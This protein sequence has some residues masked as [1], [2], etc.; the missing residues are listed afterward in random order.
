MD[1]E[2][3]FREI[4]DFLKIHEY[5]HSTELMERYPHK[6][7]TPYHDWVREL[8]D[9]S[10]EDLLN[11]EKNFDISLI[12][13]ETFKEFITKC[14]TLSEIPYLKVQ[15]DTISGQ[16]T[17]KLNPKK[18]HELKKIKTLVNKKED[19][20]T[21]IDIGSGAGH[22]SSVLVKDRDLHSICIDMDSDFQK[23]GQKKISHW[24]PEIKDKITFIPHKISNDNFCPIE[25]DKEKS[26][27]IG[28][29][30]CGPLSTYLIQQMP[31]H[32][33]N[34]SCC[35][36]KLHDEY[37]LSLIAK[38]KPLRFTNHALTMAAKCLGT[39]MIDDLTTKFLVKSYRYPIHFHLIDHGKDKF[40]NLGNAKAVDYKGSF[41][42]YIQKYCPDLMHEN[43]SLK[44]KEVD[45][46]FKAGSIRAMLGRLIEIYIILDRVLYLKE[47][48]LNANIYQVFDPKISPRNIAILI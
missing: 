22:L 11:F 19:I 8:L 27:L 25:Y 6:L 21:L 38:K 23:Q 15:D 29:H 41:S 17:R 9:F 37:N 13:S 10:I 33:I 45:Y 36:H 31:K 40:I 3:R 12:Q 5:L 42:N 30:S 35:Y 48:E 7:K 18:I 14:Q 24:L 2:K 44:E 16:Y 39:Q 43:V 34:F 32:L 47:N 46:Y 4:K 28:L 26:L 20:T 1:Y